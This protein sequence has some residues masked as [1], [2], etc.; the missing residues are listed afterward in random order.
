MM[1]MARCGPMC[2][3]RPARKKRRSRTLLASRLFVCVSVGMCGGVL[4]G[5]HRQVRGLCVPLDRA[6]EACAIWCVD[7]HRTAA[8]GPHLA[9]LKI[10]TTCAR[11][12][13]SA[14]RA[15]AQRRPRSTVVLAQGAD[16]RIRRQPVVREAGAH[17]VHLRAAAAAALDEVARRAAEHVPGRVR[18]LLLAL[19][20][21]LLADA[22]H[23]P[24]HLL[25][26]REPRSEE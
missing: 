1:R 13:M 21:L 23:G 3:L 11:H 26:T 5:G 20:R 19:D 25:V 7:V 24:L 12:K 2:A 17:W 10:Y 6:R 14:L 8:G 22:A 18:L 16:P 15:N 9:Q 4:C